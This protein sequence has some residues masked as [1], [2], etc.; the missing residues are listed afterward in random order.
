MNNIQ[1]K[2]KRSLDIHYDVC[3]FL[4]K[5]DL[6]QTLCS[7]LIAGRVYLGEGIYTLVLSVDG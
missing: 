7:K 5:K 4:D 2:K 3:L 1:D 6:G